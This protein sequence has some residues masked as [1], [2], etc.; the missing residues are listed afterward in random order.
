MTDL[1]T[2]TGLGTWWE[3]RYPGIRCDI[4]S[5]VYQYTWNPK[6]W[7]EYYAGGAEILQYFK[8]T[9]DEFDLR[10][11]LRLR[12]RVD[13]AEWQEDAGKWKIFITNLVENKQFEDECD[14]FVNAMGF[15]KQVAYI[16]TRNVRRC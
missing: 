3:N 12:H 16:S 7:S 9:V 14:I 6:V 8:N 10:P 15:L 4:P 5:V 11:L 13:R 1:S 2:R